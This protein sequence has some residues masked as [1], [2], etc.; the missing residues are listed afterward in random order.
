MAAVGR[1][2][3][4]SISGGQAAWIYLTKSETGYPDVRNLIAYRQ[5][6]STGHRGN[7][8]NLACYWVADFFQ[9]GWEP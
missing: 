2:E 3:G 9:V 5:F 6:P 4:L 1:R 7:H 8:P